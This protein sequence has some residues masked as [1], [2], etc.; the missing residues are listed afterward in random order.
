MLEGIYL[1]LWHMKYQ[2]I[3]EYHI[4]SDHL[5]HLDSTDYKL[6]HVHKLH[7]NS[8]VTLLLHRVYMSLWMMRD[9]FLSLESNNGDRPLLCHE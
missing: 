4:V 5:I 8:N 1:M 9:Q 7:F 2:C 3:R 6:I